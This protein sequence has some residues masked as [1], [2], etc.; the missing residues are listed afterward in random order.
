MGIIIAIVFA[1]L[2]GWLTQWSYEKYISH[3]DCGCAK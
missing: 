3:S 1:V 2:L